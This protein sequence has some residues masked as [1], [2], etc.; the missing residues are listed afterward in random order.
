MRSEW[1]NVKDEGGYGAVIVEQVASASQMAAEEFLDTI[2]KFLGL[3]G[4][5]CGAVS[6]HTQVRMV[7]V[8]D[9]QGHKKEATMTKQ[10]GQY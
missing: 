9:C 6:A 2:S 10:L 1:D 5:E 7:D 4:E 8:S 3:I